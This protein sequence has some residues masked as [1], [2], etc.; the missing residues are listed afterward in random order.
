[1]TDTRNAGDLQSVDLGDAMHIAKPIVQSSPEIPACALD[2]ELKSLTVDVVCMEVIFQRLHMNSSIALPLFGL[3]ALLLLLLFWYLVNSGP[4]NLFLT[5]FLGVMLVIPAYSLRYRLVI[6]GNGFKL[7]LPQRSQN[8]GLGKNASKFAW[9]ELVSVRH[10]RYLPSSIERLWKKKPV[11]LICLHFRKRTVE[12]NWNRLKQST[13]EEFIIWLSR[14]AGKE[15]ITPEVQYLIADTLLGQHTGAEC[16]T[17]TWLDEYKQKFELVNYVPLPSGTVIG[18]QLRIVLPLTVRSTT[19]TYLAMRTDGSKVVIKEILVG[20]DSENLE[21]KKA[22]QQFDREASILARLDH[23]QI[24]KIHDHF[25]ENGRNYIVMEYLSGINLRQYVNRNGPLSEVTV[26]AIANQLVDMISYLHNQNPP[27]VHRDIT[28]DNVLFD[29]Q[30]MNVSLVDFGAANVFLSRGTSTLIG[31]QNYM[32]PE[33]FR[34][35]TEPASDRY[36]FGATLYFLLSGKDPVP[37]S[38]LKLEECNPCSPAMRELLS[39]LGAISLESRP[40]WPQ[41]KE[42]LL[43]EPRV[44]SCAE[45]VS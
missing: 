26:R 37:F 39:R 32:P 34:G 24:V 43:C 11:E 13:R 33:Q 3:G 27:V 18:Q 41:V 8:G 35:K 20:D 29:D 25:I 42:C 31:K 16:F 36:A 5:A 15:A 4:L 14:Y 12:I 17:Q 2:A 10:E 22:L 9:D 19:S 7:G 40:S 45:T 44:E 1:M 38:E 21:Q 30:T 6:D 28:P 23:P